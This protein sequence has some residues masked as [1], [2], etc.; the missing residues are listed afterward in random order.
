MLFFFLVVLFDHLNYHREGDDEGSIDTGS[1]VDG[2]AV[3]ED[4]ELATYLREQVAIGIGDSK[5]PAPDIAI[6]MEHH[7]VSALDLKTFTKELELFVDA[8][9]DL[10]VAVDLV[11]GQQREYA[12]LDLYQCLPAIAIIH[13]KVVADVEEFAA[14]LKN[15]LP[16]SSR[17]TNASVRLH[18]R[19]RM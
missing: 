5:I 2:V 9:P 1:H 13:H 15:R 17:T 11:M 4:G 6:D 19:S 3:A 16:A 12:L 18:A 10:A 7:P 14:Y 8:R